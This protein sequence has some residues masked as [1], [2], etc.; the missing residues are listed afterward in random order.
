M[1]SLPPSIF[2]LVDTERMD[3][4]RRKGLLTGALYHVWSNL[5]VP[6]VDGSVDIE[7]IKRFLA[8]MVE[9]HR[10]WLQV[11]E[12]VLKHYGTD[13]TFQSIIDEVN[14]AAPE[15]DT[16][17]RRPGTAEAERPQPREKKSRRS[18]EDREESGEAPAEEA[19]TEG[20]TC[21]LCRGAGYESTSE[22]ATIV[23]CECD[24]SGRA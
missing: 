4:E 10:F 11:Y 22:G 6:R 18:V 19:T 24:G 7:K 13:A 23:C 17:P 8:D 21:G 3:P 1:A 2:A 14:N 5:P 9:T 20:V 15:R 12:A 16:D